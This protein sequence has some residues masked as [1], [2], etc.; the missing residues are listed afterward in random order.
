MKGRVFKRCSRCNATVSNRRCARCS[1]DQYT[2]AFIVDVG[3]SAAGGRKQR[4]R[5][6][7]TTRREAER[8]LRELL[9]KL[10]TQRYVTPDGSTLANFVEDEWLPAVRP[11]NLRAAT[12]T[13]YRDELRRHVL[14]TLGA[15]PVQQLTPVQLNQLYAHLLAHGRRDGQGGLSPRTVRYIHTVLRKSLADALR[16]GRVERNV[17]DLADPPRQV[18][19]R[20]GGH[21][22]IWTAPQLRQFL[23]HVGDDRLYPAWRLAATTGMR[24][25][26][27]LGLRWIDVDLDA[28]RLAVRQAYISIDGRAQFSEPKTRQ[29]RRTIDL[30]ARTVDVLRGWATEQQAEQE[31]WADA[32]EDHGLVFT[33]EDG[34][35][36]PPD[37]FSKLFGRHASAAGLRPIRLHDLRHTHASLLLASGVNPKVASERLGHHS[38]AFTLDVYS[39]VVPGM[40]AAA[41]ERVAEMI[42]DDDP[43]ERPKDDP[44]E[45][46]SGGALDDV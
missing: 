12:W 2:W 23:A 39:H 8:A 18:A 40:Q 9:H 31:A 26:E 42:F 16:W 3:R 28:G 46:P 19:S 45:G 1:S 13:S 4:R 25:A 27:V 14:P 22:Q 34:S 37:R 17:A 30:D 15:V 35:P 6:G 33:R 11:P 44:D 43:P 7:F 36:I 32:G 10:D 21:M 41:A 20:H 38:V 5:Q 29:S 24:R